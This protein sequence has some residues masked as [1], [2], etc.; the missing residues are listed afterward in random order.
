MSKPMPELTKEELLDEKTKIPA[1]R[2]WFAE[3]GRRYFESLGRVSLEPK[4]SENE[5]LNFKYLQAA[6]SLNAFYDCHIKPEGYFETEREKICSAIIE[7]GGTIVDMH[8]AGVDALYCACLSDPYTD[9]EILAKTVYW[10][11]PF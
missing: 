10:H 4:L 3:K 11:I 6:Y 9:K 1:Y 2:K 7:W 5:M 8:Q